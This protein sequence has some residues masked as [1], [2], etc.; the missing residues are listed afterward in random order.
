MVKGWGGHRDGTCS[1]PSEDKKGKKKLFT[2]KKK[3]L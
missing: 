1:S 3:M 2:Y